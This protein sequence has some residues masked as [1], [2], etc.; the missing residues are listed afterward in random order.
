MRYVKLRITTLQIIC[1]PALDVSSI[2]ADNVAQILINLQ[3]SFNFRVKIHDTC[4]W[5]PAAVWI[6][7]YSLSQVKFPFRMILLAVFRF[8][9]IFPNWYWLKFQRAKNIMFKSLTF[10]EAPSAAESGLLDRRHDRS[11]LAYLLRYTSPSLSMFALYSA[12][13]PK[14]QDWNIFIPIRHLEL[15]DRFRKNIVPHLR[16][17]M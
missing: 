12:Q 16:L 1:V 11:W 13:A 3:N 15:H 17:W 7:R 8:K 4:C 14:L 10:W 6:I 5:T 2:S 9:E